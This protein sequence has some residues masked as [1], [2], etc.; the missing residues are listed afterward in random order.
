MTGSFRIPEGGRID[1][2]APVQFGFD[3]NEYSGCTGD[4]LAAALLANGVH[5]VGRSF[6]YH[7]PRGILSAGAEEP[8][9]LVSVVRDHGRTTP[10][11]RATQIELY[12]GLNTHSQNR[13]PSLRFDLG[14]FATIASPLLGAGFYYKTFMWP[15]GF[16]RHVYEPAIRRAAGLG[17]APR[18]PDP[19][20][21]LHRYAHCEVLVIGSGAAGLA[22]ARAA[23]QSGGRV[24]L[25]DEQAEFGGA[26]LHETC[27]IEGRPASVWAAET[28]A[29]LHAQGVRMLPR[30]TAFGWFPDNLIGL[31]ER[32]TDH[33]ATP[34]PELPRERL[35]QVRAKEVVIAAGAVERPLVFPGNDRPGIMLA[36]AARCYLHRYGVKVGAR[37]VIATS[38]DS[39][40]RAAV[41]S[42]R[43]GIAVAMIVDARP[44]PDPALVAEAQAAG[45]EVRPATLPSGTTGRLR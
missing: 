15:P 11:L 20:R 6:K 42:H 2:A 37:A 39:A 35:W 22:A 38:D 8:N 45:I 1:R 43:G 4:T 25:C 21:Y 7:R 13:F 23:A 31:A 24:I 18:Q 41:E 12:P 34:P 17:R 40:Y 3:G 44:A 14:A 16:W 28:V 9:A 27:T 26:L 5:L 30:T 33:L 10:N 29:A 32:I 19:D 36:D